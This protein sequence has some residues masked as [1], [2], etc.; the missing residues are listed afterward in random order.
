MRV[1]YSWRREL[2]Q[3]CI[4]QA[5]VNSKSRQRVPLYFV[6]IL[7][8]LTLYLGE[9]AGVLVDAVSLCTFFECLPSS[10]SFPVLRHPLFPVK[11]SLHK[12]VYTELKGLV[13]CRIDQCRINVIKQM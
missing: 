12:Y 9:A 5:G 10:V 8:T 1:R 2:N 7:P 6:F 3:H 4:G 13:L 11:W